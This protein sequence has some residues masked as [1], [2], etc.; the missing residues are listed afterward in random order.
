[1][2]IGNFDGV[3]KGHQELIRTVVREAS[4]DRRATVVYTFHPHPV[5]VLHP[6]RQTERLFDLRD[7]QEQ[8][9]KMG[10]QNVVIENFTPDFA[11]VTAQEFL[12]DYVQRWFRPHT[13][14]VGHDFN[15]G[16]EREGNLA[17][18]EK[19]C[20]ENDIRLMII[21]PFHLGPQVVSSTLIRRQLRAGELTEAEHLLGRA[22]YLRGHVEKGFE[23]GRTIGV[24]TANLKPD[25]EFVPRQGVY[26]TRTLVRDRWYASVTNIGV[27]PT[28]A[29]DRKS[30][31]KI[32]THIF[33]FSGDLYGQEIEVRLIRFL[34]DEKK[35]SDINELRAQIENDM[36]AARALL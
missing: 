3:H 20:F 24:P 13:L 2:T 29:T 16:S 34:R 9:E 36:R 15:F 26:A 11:K 21:P 22:Y 33:D 32:E 25:V 18:L 35:F 14:V 27:N 5:K 30:P 7:Q 12:T 4:L 28:F 10:I 23:R 17:F 1:M 6:A 19:F 8:F 31:V